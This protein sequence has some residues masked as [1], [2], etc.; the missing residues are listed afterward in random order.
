[1]PVQIIFLVVVGIT[2]ASGVA[3]T[4][5]VMFGDTRQNNGQRVVAERFAQ[6]AMIGAIAL[7]ALLG[8][9]L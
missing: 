5:I 2:L 1:M 7:I 4:S 3:A 6:I 8:P 9:P